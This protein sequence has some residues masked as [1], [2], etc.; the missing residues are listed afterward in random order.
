MGALV[1]T[2]VVE[3]AAADIMEAV[4]EEN[5]LYLAVLEELVVPVEAGL[6]EPLEVELRVIVIQVAVVVEPVEAVREVVVELVVLV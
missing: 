5:I 4:E 1:L 6:V 2:L 3:A